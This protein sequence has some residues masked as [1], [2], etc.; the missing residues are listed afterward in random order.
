MIFNLK[1]FKVLA[2]SVFL[3]LDVCHQFFVGH[4]F[5]HVAGKQE[6]VGLD[7][8]NG[9]DAVVMCYLLAVSM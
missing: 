8:N 6:V 1:D 5:L 2:S 3:F 9:V 7:G 4:S